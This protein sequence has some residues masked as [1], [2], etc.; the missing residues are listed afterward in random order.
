LQHI[1]PITMSC[2]IGR[3]PLEFWFH[4]GLFSFIK[5]GVSYFEISVNSIHRPLKFA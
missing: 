2:L 5:R 4:T 1:H 3:E